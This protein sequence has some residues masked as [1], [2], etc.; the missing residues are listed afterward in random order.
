MHDQLSGLVD[1]E[2]AGLVEVLPDVLWVVLVSSLG[3]VLALELV[4]L[5]DVVAAVASSVPSAFLVG[6]RAV[7][8]RQGGL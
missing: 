3:Q 2:H 5:G 8:R 4:F 7:F 6:E 1:V